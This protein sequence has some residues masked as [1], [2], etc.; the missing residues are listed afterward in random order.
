VGGVDGWGGAGRW[1]EWLELGGGGEG[2]E[3]EASTISFIFKS[4]MIHLFIL[5][6]HFKMGKR[7][8]QA[9]SS[10]A[11]PNGRKNSVFC[12]TVGQYHNVYWN[13]STYVR[14]LGTGCNRAALQMGTI[15][16]LDFNAK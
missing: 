14:N 8:E 2:G 1:L 4:S 5:K 7:C 12:L 3:G 13:T 16:V 15:S 6:L 9:Y 10:A 11:P